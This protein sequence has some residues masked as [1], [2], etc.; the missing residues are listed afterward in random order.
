[1]FRPRRETVD[2]NAAADAAA[3]FYGNSAV[4]CWSSLIDI[5]K[6]N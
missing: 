6:H 4:A 5:G 3:F 2:G 1:M